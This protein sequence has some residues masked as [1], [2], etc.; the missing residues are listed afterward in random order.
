MSTQLL[1]Y[2]AVGL[3]RNY[4]L[5]IFYKVGTIDPTQE[6]MFNFDPVREFIFKGLINNNSRTTQTR[7]VGLCVLYFFTLS[8]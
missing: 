1:L 5:G 7:S 2:R 8:S 4:P 6:L 3:L